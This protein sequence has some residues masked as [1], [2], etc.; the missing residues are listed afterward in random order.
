MFLSISPVVW[1]PKKPSSGVI[2]PCTFTWGSPCRAFLSTNHFSGS[3]HK[4]QPLPWIKSSKK[5]IAVGSKSLGDFSGFETIFLGLFQVMTRQPL[6]FG[7]TRLT[8][9][10]WAPRMR[11]PRDHQD[12]ELYF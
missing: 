4:N 10:A 2:L 8:K 6:F 3:T 9:R 11:I 5:K 1:P 7:H 12:D